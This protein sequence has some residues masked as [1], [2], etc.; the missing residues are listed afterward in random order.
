MTDSPVPAAP[1]DILREALFRYIDGW[2]RD[3]QVP[4]K[5]SF[6]AAVFGKRLSRIA[7]ELTLTELITADP[8]YD[9]R[10]TKRGGLL[11]VPVVSFQEIMAKPTP[12]EVD[13]FWLSHGVDR[14]E[15]ALN[16]LD[17]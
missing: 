11:V 8:R 16:R 4:V 6:V 2:Y 1:L 15:D 9:A 17:L 3:Y 14:L 10:R 7:P 12:K 5:L 13:R